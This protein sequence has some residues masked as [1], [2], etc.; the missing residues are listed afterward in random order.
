MTKKYKQ[1]KVIENLNKFKEKLYKDIIS[2]YNMIYK[3]RMYE[4]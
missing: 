2:L 1:G 4:I 3:R